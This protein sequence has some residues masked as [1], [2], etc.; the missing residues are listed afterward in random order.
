MY[1]AL[2][3][4][5]LGYGLW[6][7][8]TPLAVPSKHSAGTQELLRERGLGCPVR[9]AVACAYELVYSHNALFNHMASHEGFFLVTFG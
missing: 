5:L 7:G 8:T 2:C 4:A 9:T 1:D 3:L 6:A